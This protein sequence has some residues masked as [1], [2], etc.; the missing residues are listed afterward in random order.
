MKKYLVLSA[1]SLVLAAPRSASAHCDTMDGPVVKTAQ[2]ALDTGKLGPV[3]AWVQAKDEAEIRAA[4]DKALA[5]RKL[6][7]EAK[8]LADRFFFEAVVRVHR[9]GEGAPYSGLKP[10]GS[11][12]DPAL[13]ASDKAVETGK[14]EPVAKLLGDSVKA[15]LAERF[16]RLRSLAAP[17]DDPAKGRE[18]VEAY[19]TYLHYALGVHQAATGTGTEAEGDGEAHGARHHD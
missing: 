9:A 17:G 19:V 8:E 1:L 7:P 13:A 2:K 4:F 18:W 16:K 5:V 12:H 14:L 10:A 6:G 15:G 3:L 11:K